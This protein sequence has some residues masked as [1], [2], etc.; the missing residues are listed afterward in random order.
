MCANA[1]SFEGLE[2]TVINSAGLIESCMERINCEAT[3]HYIIVFGYFNMLAF[4][5]DDYNLVR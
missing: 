1:F 3:K 5:F 4:N 2:I